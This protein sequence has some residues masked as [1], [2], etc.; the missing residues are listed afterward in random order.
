MH[1]NLNSMLNS[2]NLKK[3][4]STHDQSEGD[5]FRVGKEGRGRGRGNYDTKNKQ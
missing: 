3:K 1:F 2:K 5:S 4:Q